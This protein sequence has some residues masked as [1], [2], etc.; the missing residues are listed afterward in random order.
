MRRKSFCCYSG[1]IIVVW[2][3]LIANYSRSFFSGVQSY[4]LPYVPILSY[5]FL[6]ELVLKLFHF[7]R[8]IGFHLLNKHFLLFMFCCFVFLA[9]LLHFCFNSRCWT[10]PSQCELCYVTGVSLH[11][12]RIGK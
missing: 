6:E 10:H 11:Q 12:K 8:L 4:A 9:A 5:L 2:W 3:D 7:V 1:C